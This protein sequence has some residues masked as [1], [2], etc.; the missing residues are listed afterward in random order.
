MQP[1]AWCCCYGARL[2]LTAVGLVLISV[3]VKDRDSLVLTAVGLV[4]ISVVVKDRDSLVL[5]A[6]GLVLV[7]VVVKELVWYF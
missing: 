4:L 5:T 2:A 3:V 7:S 1:L 6:V